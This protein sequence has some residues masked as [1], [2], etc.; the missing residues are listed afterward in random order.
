MA[1]PRARRRDR[2][3]LGRRPSRPRGRR[4]QPDVRT[5]RPD[6]HLLRRTT[7]T[8]SPKQ[9]RGA[10]CQRGPTAS[11]C[12]ALSSRHDPPNTIELTAVAEG[13]RPKERSPCRGRVRPVEEPALR[14]VRQSHVV[15]AVGVDDETDDKRGAPWLRRRRPCWTGCSGA[16]RQA[17]HSRPKRRTQH[18]EHPSRRHQIRVENLSR[19]RRRLR[20]LHL[21]DALPGW[22]HW[23]PC[24]SQLPARQG[25]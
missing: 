10:R 20:R 6:G 11:S 23:S 16:R 15:D 2:N 4:T 25:I 19:R 13:G 24:K 14:A 8:S 17:R 3:R 5:G 9:S 18:P 7:A 12:P 22:S 21:R 1:V